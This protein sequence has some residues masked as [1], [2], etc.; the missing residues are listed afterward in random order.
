MSAAD[1]IRVLLS[2]KGEY[3]VA[4]CLGYDIGA[5][6]RDLGELRKR[7]LMA[8]RAERDESLRRHGKPLAGVGPAP[9]HFHDLWLR[10]AGEF[11]PVNPAALPDAPDIEIEFGLAA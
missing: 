10:R 7:L 6:A 11:K 1:P 8:I 3:W 9:R 5:Q 4:Q 2:K